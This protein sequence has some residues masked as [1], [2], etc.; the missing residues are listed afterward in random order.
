MKDLINIEQDLTKLSGEHNLILQQTNLVHVN[1]EPGRGLAQQLHDRWPH[2]H[3]YDR[4]G[5]Q[6]DMGSI[7]IISS[8]DNSPTICC[9]NAQRNVGRKQIKDDYSERLVAFDAALEKV[10]AVLQNGELKNI[11]KI[12][13]PYK[14]GCGY[15][16]G[17]WQEYYARIDRFSQN[18]SQPCYLCH[19]L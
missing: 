16:H 15:G 7:R 18:V 4:N 2:C 13:I 3:P 5:V 1:G 8:L 17:D 11:E 14:I 10:K 6:P 9:L 19:L 12:Y